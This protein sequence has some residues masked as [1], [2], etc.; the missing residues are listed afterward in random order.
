MLCVNTFWS[1]CLTG[2]WHFL[3]FSISLI[4]WPQVHGWKQLLFP[5]VVPC[6]VN[7][8]D[9]MEW[10][11]K[12]VIWSVPPFNVTIS[13]PF[14]LSHYLADR[15]PTQIFVVINFKM[16]LMFTRYIYK[17]SHSRISTIFMV[18]ILF[19]SQVNCFY[20]LCPCL[21]FL[22][23]LFQVALCYPFFFSSMHSISIDF[24]QNH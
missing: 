20:S 8:L 24:L 4:F 12:E 2:A 11:I 13:A 19:H 17:H 7:P 5:A 14:S 18:I 9:W 6:N 22:L 23:L 10:R 1:A 15:S 21:I 16:T 3:F